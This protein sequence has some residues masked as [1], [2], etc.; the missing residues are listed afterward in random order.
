[1]SKGIE[2]VKTQQVHETLLSQYCKAKPPITPEAVKSAAAVWSGGTTTAVSGWTARPI[3]S[4][5]PT[6]VVL[7]RVEGE[8]FPAFGKLSER[9]THTT[10]GS[11]NSW[12]A[13]GDVATAET[14]IDVEGI[15]DWLAVESAG[16]PPGWV[17]VT[18][19]AGQGPRELSREWAKGK[20]IIVGGRTDEP[21][22]EGLNQ[23]AAA[24][25]Q[26][27]AAETFASA[28]AVSR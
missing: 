6:A 21:G 8:P 17:A 16:L 2:S 10:R 7:L 18:N 20:K 27:G 4:P 19:T 23:S 24:Y 11:V 28:V 9:K 13:S 1:M 15:T 5:T 3:D 25:F 12:L 14:V 22:Q 26:A